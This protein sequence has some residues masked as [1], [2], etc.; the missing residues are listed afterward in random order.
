MNVNENERYG[1][2]LIYDVIELFST[3]E[4]LAFSKVNN[5]ISK[6]TENKFRGMMDDSNNLFDNLYNLFNIYNICVEKQNRSN[7]YYKMLISNITKD[8]YNDLLEDFQ[9]SLEYTENIDNFIRFLKNK[10]SLKL[11]ITFFIPIIEQDSEFAEDILLD[12]TCIYFNII[13]KFLNKTGFKSILYKICLEIIDA[14]TFYFIYNDDS[15][16]ILIN[17]KMIHNILKLK[18][19]LN[20]ELHG[21]QVNIFVDFLFSIKD[22]KLNETIGNDGFLVVSNIM[23]QYG[24]EEAEQLANV[25]EKSGDMAPLQAVKRCIEIMKEDMDN[26]KKLA[27]N[28]FKQLD[29][30]L[31]FENTIKGFGKDI[32]NNGDQIEKLIN[33]NSNIGKEN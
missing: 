5:N 6:L 8:I 7:V 2:K 24:G 29:I 12:D 14:L 15:N 9:K 28:T 22:K 10:D 11:D 30:E 26:T 21:T 32:I 3:N 4:E 33:G 13:I 17:A 16:N 31:P 18:S 23:R 25:I 19:D 20:V 1:I 27:L